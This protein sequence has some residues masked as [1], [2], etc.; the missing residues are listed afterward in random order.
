[1]KAGEIWIRAL[2]ATLLHVVLLA[3]WPLVEPVYA[4]AF[5]ASAGLVFGVIPPLPAALEISLEPG[6]GGPMAEDM[7]RMDTIVGL[8]PRALE[9]E[10]ATFG[11]SSFFHGYYPLCVLLALF[12][13]ATPRPW[14]ARRRP[15]LW[16]LVLLHAGLALRFLPA[17]YYCY[18]KCNIDGRAPLGLGPG[19]T[20]ALHMLKHFAWEEVLP[21]YL[22]PLFVFALC[23]FGPR[24]SAER[25][26]PSARA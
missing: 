20:R 3:A 6:S 10:P 13:A 4:P 23:V 24:S 18:S 21:N 19:G 2:A 25:G 9:G 7:V 11:A 1:M 16:A 17:L 8:S 12:A 15:F 22:L 26:V 5:R 14:R